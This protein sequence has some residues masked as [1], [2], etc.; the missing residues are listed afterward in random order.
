MIIIIIWEVNHYIDML[1][2]NVKQG[3]R[4]IWPSLKPGLR[5]KAAGVAAGG[6]LIDA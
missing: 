5:L 6:W 2:E 4:D 3:V 1:S